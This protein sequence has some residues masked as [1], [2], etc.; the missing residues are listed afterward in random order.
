M[1]W[2]TAGWL[3]LTKGLPLPD[4]AGSNCGD[5]RLGLRGPNENTERNGLL[6][7]GRRTVFIGEKRLIQ[8]IAVAGLS[9]ALSIGPPS[10]SRA[11]DAAPA[12]AAADAKAPAKTLNRPPPKILRSR[13]MI[14]SFCWSR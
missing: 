4:G 5:R 7:F 12:P 13:S 1:A 11:E 8:L 2:K 10:A 9:F 3:T 6:G 14:S